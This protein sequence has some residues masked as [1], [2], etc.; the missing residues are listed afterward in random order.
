MMNHLTAKKIRRGTLNNH[1]ALPIAFVFILLSL[2]LPLNTNGQSN[3]L[4]IIGG[5]NASTHLDNFRYERADI[6]LDFEPKLSLGYQ[7]GFVFRRSISP[8]LRFQAEPSVMM[9]GARYNEPFELRNH[10]LE[11]DSK[12]DLTYIQLPLLLQVTTLPNQRPAYG[13][14]KAS[15]TYHLT[16]G[17]YGGYL[18]DA[19]FSGTNSGAPLGVEFEGEFSN[20]ISD[21]YS[22]FDGGVIVGAGFERGLHNKLGFEVRGLLSVI[23]TGD[24]PDLSFEPRNVGVTFSVYFL[25]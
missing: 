1:Q 3:G 9:L 8:S 4:G 24:A 10:E 13:R 14:Q 5:L 7:G 12:T 15:T 23:N 19:E 25:I 16:G 22:D 17:F 6:D 20:N 2:S 18:V 21:Q 11:T